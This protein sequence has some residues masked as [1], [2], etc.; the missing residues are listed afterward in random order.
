MYLNY[1]SQ[2]MCVSMNQ[3]MILLTF[4]MLLIDQSLSTEPRP[5]LEM[6][7]LDKFA[8]YNSLVDCFTTIK[9][10]FSACNQEA[11]E[12][13]EIVLKYID[14]H[15]ELGTLLKCCG[16][17]IV[18]DCWVASAKDRCQQAAVDQLHTLP[19]KFAPALQDACSDYQPGSAYCFLP[20]LI[21]GFVI[22]LLILIIITIAAGGVY[23][24]KRYQ[25]LKQHIRVDT[26][27]TDINNHSNNN[28]NDRLKDVK[29]NNV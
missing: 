17:W 25:R 9:E 20:F 5:G 7:S 18:R 11:L 29:V 3:I 28:S 24:Y 4:F 21:V 15:S 13:G 23:Y 27:S 1:C 16:T 12:R 2:M 22:V 19:V 8:E 26:E 6:L 14:E 10:E